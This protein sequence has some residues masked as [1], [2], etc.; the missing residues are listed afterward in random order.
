MSEYKK[1]VMNRWKK[2]NKQK[3]KG[4]RHFFIN[5]QGK[6]FHI[7]SL[8]TNYEKFYSWNN[9]FWSS[10]SASLILPSPS[11]RDALRWIRNRLNDND[12][13][14]DGLIDWLMNLF[15]RRWNAGITLIFFSL[16]LLFL[17]PFFFFLL[18]DG[19]SLTLEFRTRLSVS[20]SEFHR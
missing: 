7:F 15:I 1:Y 18:G 17:F 9:Y 3:K 12:Y 20:S 5:I 14:I 13:L 11:F 19:L 6:Y 2:T 8:H 16:F 4:K 10:F